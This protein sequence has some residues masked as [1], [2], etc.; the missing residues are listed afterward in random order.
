LDFT[1]LLLD[2]TGVRKTSM[3]VHI[4]HTQKLTKLAKHISC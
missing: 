3:S 1:T 4:V 2:S